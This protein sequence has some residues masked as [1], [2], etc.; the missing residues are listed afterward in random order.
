MFYTFAELA[1]G[2][3]GK[4]ENDIL[5]MA[6]AGKLKLSVF[7]SGGYW[8][9][10]AAG[11]CYDPKTGPLNDFIT[12]ESNHAVSFLAGLYLE[13]DGGVEISHGHTKDGQEVFPWIPYHPEYNKHTGH[14]PNTTV[15][16]PIFPL[17]KILI[18]SEEVERVNAEEENSLL[19]IHKKKGPD[20]D[21]TK[22]AIIGALLV[23]LKENS[24][25]KTN[26]AIKN[27]IEKLKIDVK[28]SDTTMDEVFA[29]AKKLILLKN[30]RIT[31][32]IS[33]NRP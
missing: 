33:Q 9:K 16:P 31:L 19:G 27:A 18:L 10:D 29:D 24:E 4:T 14:D 11:N 20:P 17:S 22:L 21:K 30:P 1:N 8:K 28:F 7:W 25:I 23:L 5:R 6:A 13:E 12:I 15:Y 26:V 3:S 32:Q 2:W